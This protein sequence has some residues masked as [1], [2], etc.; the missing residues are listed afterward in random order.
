MTK[1]LL[2]ITGVLCYVTFSVAHANTIFEG[3]KLAEV[4]ASDARYTLLNANEYQQTVVASRN[5]VQQLLQAL[6]DYRQQS[7]NDQVAFIVKQLLNVPYSAYGATGEGDWQPASLTYKP[8]AVHVQQDPVYHLDSLDCQTFVEVAMA[9]LHANTIDDFD[10]DFVR[11]GYGAAGNYQ[12]EYVHYYNR[13]NFVDG[14]F[15]PINQQNE[16]LSD[17]TSH[18]LAAYAKTQTATLTRQN[19]FNHQ[20]LKLSQNVRVLNDQD[21]LPMAKRFSSVYTNLPFP[22]FKSQKISISYLPIKSL[23]LKQP[24][25]SYLPNQELLDKIP[26]PAVVEAVRDPALWMIGNKSVKDAIGS[27]LTISHMGL[28]YRQKFSQGEVIYQDVKCNMQDGSKVCEVTPM[29]CKQASC[30]ELMFAHATDRYPDGY[31]WYQK[32]NGNYVCSTE[33]PAAGQVKQY[34]NRLEAVPLFKYITSYQY[35][36]YLYMNNPSIDGVHVEKLL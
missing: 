28:L 34:C 15:N 7:L 23:A 4:P 5:K 9:L 1:L 12:N 36:N 10:R 3:L 26:T 8:G 21:G 25:G 30:T 32:A 13:N 2:I 22:N 19:W 27:E 17:V 11:I 33:A 31:Y 24:D 16:L 14:E 18:E 29:A 6:T 35:G 20:L